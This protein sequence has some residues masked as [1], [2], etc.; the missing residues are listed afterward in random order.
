[1]ENKRDKNSIVG[2]DKGLHILTETKDLQIDRLH[3]PTESKDSQNTRSH[4][5]TQNIITRFK[6]TV[7]VLLL[8][9]DNLYVG[10]T[11]ISPH[12]R[13]QEHISGEFAAEWTKLHPPVKIL[14]STPG[15]TT[16]ERDI[17]LALSKQCGYTRVRGG[18]W[19]KVEMRGALNYLNVKPE[20]DELIRKNIPNELR[21]NDPK[22]NGRCLRCNNLPHGECFA[23]KYYAP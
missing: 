13:F 20:I 19:C 9:D 10:H 3:I 12:A 21:T 11:K 1:M 17:T 18:P 5:Q 2:L 23:G 6:G 22:L 14:F 8:K 4:P 16:L 7:Y 15:D